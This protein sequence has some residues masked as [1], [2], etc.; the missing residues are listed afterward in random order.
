MNKYVKEFLH[1]GL[2]FGG[3]GPIIMG[4]IYLVLSYVIKDFV[5]GG[6]EVFVVTVS[7]YLL[8]FIHAGSSVFN[9]IEHWSTMKGLLWQL[10]SLYVTYTACYLLNSWIPF[11][12]SVIVIFTVIFVVAYLA[13]WAVVYLC[14]K[15]NAKKLSEKLV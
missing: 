10:G 14:V 12:F 7:I 5:L 3:F 1:R 2:M 11:D 13:I 6:D 9:Q 15:G 4:I 8:A